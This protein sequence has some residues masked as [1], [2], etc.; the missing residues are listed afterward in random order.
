MRRIIVGGCYAQRNASELATRYPEVDCFIGI[1]QAPRIHEIVR[2]LVSRPGGK[3]LVEVSDGA[4]RWLYDDSTPRIQVT[5]PSYAYVKIA[6]GCNH[7]C[8]FCAIPGIRGDLRSRQPES[9]VAE[10]RQLLSNGVRELDLI[11]QDSTAYG[12]DLAPRPSLAGLLRR[13]DELP[14]DFWIRV[15]YT[16]PL[17]LTPEFLE[18]LGGSRH[19]VPYLDVPLQH[20]SD[21]ILKSMRRGMTSA[22]TRE[23][24]L[25]IREKWPSMVIRT[26]FM[27]GYPGET[28]EAFRQLL[29][30]TREMRFDRMGAFA[31][32]PEPGTP[33]AQIQDGLVP[34]EVAEERRAMLLDLQREIS[35]ERNRGWLGKKLRVLVE[36]PLAK[37]LWSARGAGEAPEVDPQV[38]VKA[39]ATRPPKANSFMDVKVTRADDYDLT[40]QP[41]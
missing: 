21:P 40:A 12:Y 20:I 10:C 23:L 26:T 15:L 33:A 14:G 8:A 11:A 41:L 34:P 22:R 16:H 38:F 36:E 13:L 1:D 39:P 28:E 9:V 3:P 5:S 30:F 29:D 7:R 19:V 24:L 35:R 27:T 4:P 6:E 17:H 18:V 2:A 37:G 32:S 31:F 25:S